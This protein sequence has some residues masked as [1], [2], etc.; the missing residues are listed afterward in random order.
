[1][2]RRLPAVYISIIRFCKNVDNGTGH[3]LILALL[4]CAAV[5][6]SDACMGPAMT[7]TNFQQYTYLLLAL[8]SPFLEFCGLQ[9]VLPLLP[10]TPLSLLLS[11][12]VR[13]TC[14]S[15]QDKIGVS[16]G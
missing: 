2:Y 10:L 12:P 13:I 11:Q 9:L 16:T 7:L 6:N 1:M 14:I 4:G 3:I 8:F 15:C 5:E